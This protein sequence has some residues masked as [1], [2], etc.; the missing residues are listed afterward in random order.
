MC[1]F[2]K[3]AKIAETRHIY[4]FTVA[5]PAPNK[6]GSVVMRKFR[7]FWEQ[8]VQYKG[9]PPSHRRRMEREAK[10]KVFALVWVAEFVQFI[11][12]L[13]FLPRSICKKRL[14]STLQYVPQTDATTFA[15]ASLSPSFIYAP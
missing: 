13:Y 12:V 14:N 8:C 2:S 1:A 15:V 4:I 3:I 5:P 11:A 9:E 10:A 6:T 7:S